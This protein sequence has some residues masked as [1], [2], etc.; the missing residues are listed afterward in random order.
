MS[1]QKFTAAGFGKYFVSVQGAAGALIEVRPHSPG[2]PL[3]NVSGYACIAKGVNGDP[4]IVLSQSNAQDLI[5]A[6]TPF[7]NTGVFS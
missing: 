3:G 4:D 7:A 1:A 2:I 6:L 5:T